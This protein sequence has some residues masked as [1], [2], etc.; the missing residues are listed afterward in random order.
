MYLIPDPAAPAA[1]G[2]AVHAEC[3]FTRGVVL[4]ADPMPHRADAHAQL[5]TARDYLR[6]EL[7]T[8]DL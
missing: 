1:V 3:E 8:V 2:D 7:T 5:G 4:R 6:L